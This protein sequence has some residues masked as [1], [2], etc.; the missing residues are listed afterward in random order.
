M[1]TCKESS[2]KQNLDAVILHSLVDVDVSKAKSLIDELKRRDIEVTPA[3][4]V[5]DLDACLR[6]CRGRCIV[7]LS[8][9]SVSDLRENSVVCSA[10]D[11]GCDA[12]VVVMDDTLETLP[13][14]WMRFLCLRYDNQRLNQL[15]RELAL[16]IRTPLIPCRPKDITGY[17]AAFRVLNG[18]LRFV[19]PNFHKR[20][21]EL[22]PDEYESCV[23]KFMITCPES[24]RC[25]PEMEIGSIKHAD[26]CVLRNV[27]RAGQ[28]H[29]DFSESVYRIRDEERKRDYYFAAVFDNCLASLGNIQR[30]GLVGIDEARMCAERNNYILHLKQLLKHNKDARKYTGQ[31]RIL[32]WRDRIRASSLMSSYCQSLG[33]NWKA[34]RKRCLSRP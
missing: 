8:P 10:L 24:C 17:A 4:P 15:C 31:Y 1:Y 11:R 32:Y 19:L 30:S 5:S 25:P 27:T 26:E 28:Q 34:N 16:L 23:K 21:K 22:H 9:Q 14:E 12:V 29:R 18:Y 2:S 33:K 7:Y 6:R 3:D 13:D 20:L